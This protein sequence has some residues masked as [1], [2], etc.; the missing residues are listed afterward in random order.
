MR[1]TIG[2]TILLI[3]G[4]GLLIGLLVPQA[5]AGDGWLSP[6]AKMRIETN[7]SRRH[8][9]IA[10]VRINRAM[11]NQARRHSLAM[12]RRGELFHT[13]S[14]ASVYLDGVHWRAWGENVGVTSGSI[15]GLQR[16]FMASYGHRRNVLNRSFH[17]VAIG[18][19][20]VNGMLWVTVFFYG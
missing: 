5:I 4:L 15:D 14:P 2:R 9:D 17:R 12:A 16:A 18:A 3:A 20:R 10:R 8:H 1:R 7:L 19:V 13:S 6:R 11:S